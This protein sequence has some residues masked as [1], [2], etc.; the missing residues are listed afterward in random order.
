M[1]FEASQGSYLRLDEYLIHQPKGIESLVDS[2]GRRLPRSIIQKLHIA[3]MMIGQP[4]LL[5]IEDPMEFIEEEEK[6]SIID[7]IMSKERN[8]TVLVVSDYYYWKERCDRIL[9]LD[10]IQ[11]S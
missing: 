5:L 1:R 6:K 4:R 3:R 2:G 10:P 9:E 8:W 11:K 7:F